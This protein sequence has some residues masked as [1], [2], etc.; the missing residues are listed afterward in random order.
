MLSRRTAL[1][2]LGT[3]PIA[4]AH[5]AASTRPAEQPETPHPMAG[6]L[7]QRRAPFSGLPHEC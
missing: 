6:S 7:D 1:A 4:A 2:A 3:V 5:A